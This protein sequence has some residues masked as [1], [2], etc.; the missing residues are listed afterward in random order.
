LIP[1]LEDEVLIEPDNN[2]NK[3]DPLKDKTEISKPKWL[4]DFITK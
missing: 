3:L 1:N 2:V 4:K